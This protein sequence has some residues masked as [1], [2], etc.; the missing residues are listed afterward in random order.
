MPRVTVKDDR[1]TRHR[2]ARSA[3]VDAALA[4]VARDVLTAA[5]A[6]APRGK[7]RDYVESLEIA[8]GKVDYHVNATAEHSAAVEFGHHNE[9]TYVEGQHVLARALDAVT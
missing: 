6:D 9:S 8:K 1:R 5:T 2:I 3:V 4:S 7:S